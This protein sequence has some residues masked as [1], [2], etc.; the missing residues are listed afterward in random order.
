MS[1]S[2]HLRAKTPNHGA[3]HVFF[4]FSS[5]AKS[6]QDVSW[7]KKS[8]GQFVLAHGSLV[9]PLQDLPI[10]GWLPVEIFSWT[11]VPQYLKP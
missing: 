1:C 6:G 4:D 10:Y 9:F 7:P 2:L 11:P 5:V 8:Y 3:M